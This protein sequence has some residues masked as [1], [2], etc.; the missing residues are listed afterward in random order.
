[1]PVVP[2]EALK[3]R[4]TPRQARSAATVAAIFEATIQVLLVDGYAGLTTTRV[5]ARAGV[6][7]GTMYQY[8]PHR[9]ALLYAVLEAYLE[10]VI[11]VLHAAASRLRDAPLAEIAEGLAAAYLEAKVDGMPGT[12][13]LYVVAAELETAALVT[14][15]VCRAERI[16]ADLLRG[17]PDARFDDPDRI[18]R[19]WRILLT[20]AVQVVLEKDASTENVELLRRELPAVCRAYLLASS[21][22][23]G[24]SPA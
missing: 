3:P 15:I 18:A 8:F 5:A 21:V 19:A 9:N 20:G 17:V 16:L 2:T 11:A 7:V 4:K 12:R 1:M 23:P 22:R 6:S 13:A 24:S 14:D 10:D